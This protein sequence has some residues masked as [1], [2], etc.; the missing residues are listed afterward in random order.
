[1]ATATVTFR[2]IEQ[3][4]HQDGGPDAQLLAD[5]VLDLEAEGRTWVG[6]RA[7][8]KR[9]AGAGPEDPLEVGQ[10][11]GGGYRG[12]LDYAPFRRAIEDYYR[13]A[14]GPQGRAIRLPPGTRIRME[15]SFVQL[16][17]RVVRFQYD[18]GARRA[19]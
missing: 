10:P 14:F 7:R 12:S 9:S 3:D 1:M 2:A 4:V 18:A 6:L 11:T 19:W 16:G 15:G 13:A 17:A 5:V 8:V